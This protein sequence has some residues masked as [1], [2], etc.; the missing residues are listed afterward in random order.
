MNM[1]KD[2]STPCKVLAIVSGKGGSGKTMLT[3]TIASILDESG[4][5]VLLIDADFG[6]AGLTYYLGLN[7]VSNI[8]VGLTNIFS[9][10]KSTS[11]DS[12]DIIENLNSYKNTSF[13]GV[14]DHRRYKESGGQNFFH[15]YFDDFLTI[16]KEKNIFDYIVIDCRGGIDEESITVCRSADDIIIV[17]ETD[18]TSFQATQ[19]LV[20]VLYDNGISDKITGFF[21][22]KV[23]DDP[24]VIMRN[25][26]VSFKCRYLSSIPFDLDAI[27]SFIVG[28]IPSI[29]GTFSSQIWNGL[30][31]I[32]SLNDIKK[33]IMKPLKSNQFSIVSFKDVKINIG[34]YLLSIVLFLSIFMI[35]ISLFMTNDDLYSNL[36]PFFLVSLIL[37]IFTSSDKVKKKI[38]SYY[39]K[40]LS[41]FKS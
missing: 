10:K 20:D 24:S 23:F 39:I 21:I 29:S 6:T 41:I 1:C 17:A 4:K 8:S 30:C 16:I 37:S 32:N 27:K 5:S 3:S 33:P 2:K 12:E 22:N 26:A 28:E 15:E 36:W 9:N 31:K 40:L 25:G 14:G 11:L 18:T 38:G 34:S 7:E 13:I 19:Y 35:L